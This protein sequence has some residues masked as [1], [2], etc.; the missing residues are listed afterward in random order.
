MKTKIYLVKKY[1][2][3]YDDETPTRD[4]RERA[5]VFWATD[6]RE[7]AAQDVREFK[8]RENNHDNRLYKCYWFIQE[9]ELFKALSKD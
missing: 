2:R 9:V 8:K 6:T 3:F 7:A 1:L 5:Q 4:M